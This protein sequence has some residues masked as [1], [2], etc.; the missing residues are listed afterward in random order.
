MKVDVT[1]TYTNPSSYVNFSLKSDSSTHGRNSLPL[2]LDVSFN[3]SISAELSFFIEFSSSLHFKTLSEEIAWLFNDIAF[4][5]EVAEE[6]DGALR[7]SSLGE[8]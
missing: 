3:I 7:Y 6:M 5:L 4:R 8:R 2:T 1:Y